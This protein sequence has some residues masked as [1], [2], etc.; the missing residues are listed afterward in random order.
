MGLNPDLSLLDPLLLPSKTN[1]VTP[2]LGFISQQS[3]ENK[4]QRE[5]QLTQ[6]KEC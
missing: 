6:H 4:A 1:P 5:E 3:V 2:K